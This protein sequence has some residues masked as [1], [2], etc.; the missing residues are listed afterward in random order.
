MKPTRR[1]FIKGG[2]SAFTLSF[3]AP[4]FVSDLA[5]AQGSNSRNLVIL[6]LSG[7]NDALSTVIPYQR[8]EEHTS[9]LQSH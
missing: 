8:S 5:M 6:Y 2:V 4:A 3:A 7:G 1:D 9:E